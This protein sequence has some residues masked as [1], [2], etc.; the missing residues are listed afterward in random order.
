MKRSR[1]YSKAV[2]ENPASRSRKR[3]E[4]PQEKYRKKTKRRRSKTNAPEPKYKLGEQVEGLAEDDEGN[5]G[6]YVGRIK[7]IEGGGRYKVQFYDED[8]AVLD[9]DVI[10][11]IMADPTEFKEG[12]NVV[13]T[14]W[15]DRAYNGRI[16]KLEG[17]A[18]FIHCT[19]GDEAWLSLNK[20]RQGPMWICPW[21]PEVNYHRPGTCPIDGSK[22]ENRGGPPAPIF[23]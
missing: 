4:K 18:A 1:K 13:V 8:E 15:D 2:N 19:D 12:D 16:E 17:K 21:H 10:K 6:W 5:Y 20:V 11:N 23:D 22:L 9:E 3:S 7:T 14:W